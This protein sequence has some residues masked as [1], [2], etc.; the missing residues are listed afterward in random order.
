MANNFGVKFEIEFCELLGENGFWAH[1]LSENMKGAQPFD[2]IAMKNGK[3]IAIECK[4]VGKTGL[5]P[6][7]RVEDNQLSSLTSFRENGGSAW[8]AFKL[9]D[10]RIVL[11]GAGEVFHNANIGRPSIMATNGEPFERW[12]SQF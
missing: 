9:A 3:P 11:R 1:R 12:V 4:V 5:F 10:G 7:S 8:F 2:I 6:L